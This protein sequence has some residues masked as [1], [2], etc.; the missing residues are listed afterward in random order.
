MLNCDYLLLT[1]DYW[2]PDFVLGIWNL[3]RSAFIG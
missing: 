1:T 2:F 3:K